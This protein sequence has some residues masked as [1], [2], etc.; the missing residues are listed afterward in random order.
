MHRILS[1]PE[2]LDIIFSHL[3]EPTNASNAVVC[4]AWSEVALNVLWADVDDLQRL[5]GLLVPLVVKRNVY[6]MARSPL[7]ADWKR[8]ENYAR[9]VRRL[10]YEPTAS[11]WPCPSVFAELA[12]TRLSM[13][14]L[15]NLHTLH[16]LASSSTHDP[17]L[18][19]HAKLFLHPRLTRLAAY[20]PIRASDSFIINPPDD[21][22]AEVLARAPHLVRLDLRMDVPARYISGP[23]CDLLRAL[24]ELEKVVLPEHHITSAV[25]GAL[26]T[27]P[28]LRVVQFEYGPE[29]GDG[30]AADVLA[31]AP[32]LE[33]GAFPALMDLS[34]TVPLAALTALLPSLGGLTHLY[35]DTPAVQT[36]LDVSS[37]LS[38]LPSG[39]PSLVALYLELLW[40]RPAED[41]DDDDAPLWADREREDMLTLDTLRPLL[42]LPLREF[43][44]THD[45]PLLLSP[46]EVRQLARAWPQIEV[47]VLACEPLTL[48]LGDDVGRGGGALPL[49]VLATLARLCPRLRTLG[50]FMDASEI[51]ADVAAWGVTPALNTPSCSPR[52]GKGGASDADEEEERGP[53]VPFKNL[54]KLTV[55]VSPINDA[56]AVALALSHLLP[57]TCVVECGVTWHL[58]LMPSR[59][60]P[61]PPPLPVLPAFP[62]FGQPPANPPVVPAAAPA[63]VVFGQQDEDNSAHSR[64][65][66]LAT[67]SQRCALWSTAAQ[68]LPV[69]SRVREEER[70]RTERREEEVEDLRVRVRVLMEMGAGVGE[71]RKESGCTIC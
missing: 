61:S 62:G 26:A 40:L 27:L 24:P 44:L 35:V 21:F 47:L 56:P 58:E 4:K 15:P 36:S 2:L 49:S 17:E 6:T 37:L 25:L 14:I 8:F 10:H 9:R 12:S 71:E 5:I 63:P 59:A 31:I 70:E 69:L 13:H 65:E 51:G 38:A 28:R 52:K 7:P 19:L 20:L 45:R 48:E 16:W 41:G 46:A 34:L 64:R 53:P 22:F 3:D 55:G 42:V 32:S 39:C 33:V 30:D 11:P 43:T 60:S 50:L 1:I 29:Q 18:L 57:P 67:V 66:T 54:K 68:L 23:V